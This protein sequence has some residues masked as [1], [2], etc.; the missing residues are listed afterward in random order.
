MILMY[1]VGRRGMISAKFLTL[2]R[3]PVVCFYEMGT[4]LLSLRMESCRRSQKKSYF[5]TVSWLVIIASCL[6]E[7]QNHSFKST[8]SQN[9][10]FTLSQQCLLML[11]WE[12]GPFLAIPEM[13]I[14]ISQGLK[15]VK[16]LAFCLPVEKFL[17]FQVLTYFKVLTGDKFYLG[18][19]LVRLHAEMSV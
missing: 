8:P 3:K 18:K 4:Q 19:V 15:K 6:G 12:W 9:W 16:R 17:L 1:W 13:I 7:I 10:C 11:M 5:V 14:A 2:W